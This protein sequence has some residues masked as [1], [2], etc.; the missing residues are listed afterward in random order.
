MEIKLLHKDQAVLY[1]EIRLQGLATNPEAFSASLEEETEFPI[2]RFENRLSGN[3]TFTF[4]AMEDNELVGVVTLMLEQS[5][6]T[7]HRGN[8]FGMYVLPNR[9]D[10]GIGKELLKAAIAKAKENA[11]EQIYLTVMSSNHPAKKLYQSLG[12]ETYGI[13]KKALVV[14]ETYYDEE[15]MVL[16]F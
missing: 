3:N 9:R 11:I 8:I 15:L 6:K 2:E 12:F 10:K 5:N 14:N 13:D 7:K 16:Y 1:R 4:G